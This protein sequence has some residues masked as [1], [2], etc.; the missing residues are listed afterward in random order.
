MPAQ[1]QHPQGDLALHKHTPST[2]DGMFHT[3][4]TQRCSWACGTAPLYVMV[5]QGVMCAPEKAGTYRHHRPL[6]SD[7]SFEVH[8]ANAKHHVTTS[9][10][11]ASLHPVVT[12]TALVAHSQHSCMRS[13]L[14]QSMPQ[15][16]LADKQTHETTP[17]PW[18]GVLRLVMQ[19]GPASATQVF[20]RYTQPASS[21][22]TVNCMPGAHKCLGATVH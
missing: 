6:S 21:R 10:G 20:C 9:T 17:H 3:A 7:L 1:H 22:R 4:H 5:V 15:D 18:C 13:Y 12:H 16:S 14:Q 11:S 8:T 2:A 19:Q